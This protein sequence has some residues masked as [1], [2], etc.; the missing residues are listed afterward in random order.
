MKP[1]VATCFR[2]GFLL[3]LFLDPDDGGDIFLRNV[4]SALNGLH[5]V[6]SQKIAHFITIGVSASDPAKKKNT[7]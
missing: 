7:N 5:G 1:L 4:W 2:A 3:G 6:I